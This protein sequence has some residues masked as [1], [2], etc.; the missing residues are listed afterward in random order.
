[1][2]EQE[3]AVDTYGQRDGRNV[4]V[5]MACNVGVHTGPPLMTS[6]VGSNV[7]FGGVAGMG[8][9]STSVRK[10]TSNVVVNVGSSKSVPSMGESVGMWS[11]LEGGARCRP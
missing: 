6:R 11:V 1:M 7:A 8:D 2:V 5:V 4:R 10:V 3:R 9:T